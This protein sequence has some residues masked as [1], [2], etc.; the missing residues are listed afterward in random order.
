MTFLD[1]RLSHSNLPGNVVGPRTCA[2]TY[3]TLLGRIQFTLYSSIA[4]AA[5]R[6]DPT[7]RTIG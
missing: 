3:N 2:G 7:V 5:M 1:Y 6:D 4:C